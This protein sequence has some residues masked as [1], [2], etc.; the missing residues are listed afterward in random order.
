M[1]PD[2]LIPPEYRSA[3]KKELH[4]DAVN[5]IRDK[6]DHLYNHEPSAKRETDT[7]ED[8]IEHHEKLSKHQKYI[9]ELNNLGLDTAEIQTKWHEY[10]QALSE[11]EKHEVWREFYTEQEL[12]KKQKAEAKEKEKAEKL[13]QSSAEQ[14]QAAE[15]PRKRQ[16]IEIKPIT[17]RARGL[18]FEETDYIRP[19]V[20]TPVNKPTTNPPKHSPSDQQIVSYN[21]SSEKPVAKKRS[22]LSQNARLNA[23]KNNHHVKSLIFGV[24]MGSLV[25]FILLFSFF[26]ERFI[27]PFIRPNQNV[28][29]TPIIVDPN[30]TG[31]VSAEPKIIIP[32]VNLEAPVVY[33]VPTIEEHA[34]Q[35]GLERGVVHYATTP[36]PGE[37]GNAVIFGHSSG[38]ILNK[39][40][41]KFA[42]LLLKSLDKDD[43]F[44][45]Q[46]DSKRY[47]YKV[48]NKYVTNPSDISVL[49]TIPGKPATMTL[50]TCDPP[51]T[52]TNRLIVQAEQIFP[53]PNTNAESSVPT[54]TVS[55]PQELPSNSKTLW[56]RIFGG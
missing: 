24:G 46:K 12:I 54:N 26:N 50:I 51:G 37:K 16:K 41:Y 39:G 19:E 56:Q 53:D 42:F 31:P 35:E 40:K 48:F 21:Q 10:Y 11:D 5:L 27:T 38:N 8:K 34:V 20:D 30:N 6:I 47:V 9:R 7:V 36:N 22:K 17:K 49:G 33:D 15:E 18:H 2:D 55:Q 29:A 4:E 28:S 25:V 13:K 52:S 45:I 23:I 14:S 43:T 1:N 32:K 44:I 3:N